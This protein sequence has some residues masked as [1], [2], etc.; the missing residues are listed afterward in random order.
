MKWST[1]G[2]VRSMWPRLR[3]SVATDRLWVASRA[4]TVVAI[5]LIG[6]GLVASSLRLD[7]FGLAGSLPPPYYV[8]LAMLPLAS[9]IEWRRGREASGL[10]IAMHVVVFV[11]VIWSTPLL[12]EGTPRFRT[13]YQNFGDVDPLVRGDGLL[14]SQFV[15]HN[16]PLFPIIMAALLKTGLSDLTLMGWFPIVISLAYLVPLAALL[17]LVAGETGRL[18]DGRGGEAKMSPPARAKQRDPPGADPAAVHRRDGRWLL[19]LWIFPVFDWTGQDYFSPQAF[20]YL[21][22]LVWVSVLMFV[23]LRR[24]GTFTVRT[25]ALTLILYTLI[26]MTH[27][28]TALFGLGVLTALTL[29]RLVRRPTLLV[30]ALLIFVFWQ[31]YFAAPFLTFYRDQLVQTILDAPRFLQSNLGG[32]LQG[33]PEHSEIAQLRILVSLLVFAIG[34]LAAVLLV[35][36]RPIQ[37]STKFGLAFVAGLTVVAPVSVYGGE[38]VI[39]VLLFSLPMVAV[40]VA[41]AVRFRVIPIVLIVALVVMAPLHMLTHYGNE[42]YDYVS[43]DELAGYQ[44][45]AD[46]LAPANVYGGFPA[47]RFINTVRLDSRNATVPRD[48]VLPRVNDYRFPAAHRWRNESWPV[49]VAISRGDRAAMTLFYNQPTFMSEILTVVQSDPKFQRVFDNDDMVI[50]RWLGAATAAQLSFAT[51]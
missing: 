30:T 51:P 33:S 28:L 14:P 6:L 35:R 17:R 21:L 12:L 42:L 4:L 40:L 50:Y 13:S 46:K 2:I 15:Y 48:E 5:L 3:S 10:L 27:V 47:G 38:M 36:R 32:R 11:L 22:F 45:V 7:G 39:R 1:S 18:P 20:A 49:Y 23:A 19:P 8:G 43:A 29:T 44:Y 34:A 25:I 9:G 41:G 16:W 26:V 31:V 37:R 24:D